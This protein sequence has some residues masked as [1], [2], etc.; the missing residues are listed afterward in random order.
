MRAFTL[1][2]SRFSSSCSGS[3]STAL[4][5]VANTEPEL[6]TPNPELRTEPEPEHEP[7]NENQEA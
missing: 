6:R 5:H 4:D 1:L 2:R 3:C 7:R